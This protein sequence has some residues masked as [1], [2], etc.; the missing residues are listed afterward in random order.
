MLQN[1]IIKS[2][3]V[4]AFLASAL[5][6]SKT[7]SAATIT[8]FTSNNN[9]S[10]Y[11]PV[12]IVEGYDQYNDV[13]IETYTKRVNGENVTVVGYYDRLP[14]SFTNWLRSSGRDLIFITF[15]DTHRDVRDLANEFRTALNTINQMKVGN[16]PNAVIG[17]SAGG[18]IARWGLKEMENSGLN[19][20]TSL[21]ITYDT[22]HRGASVPESIIDGLKDLK[23]KIPFGQLGE[24]EAL[25]NEWRSLTSTAAKQMLLG[26]NLSETFFRELDTLGYPEQLARMAVAN[27]SGSGVTINLPNNAIV[28]DYKAEILQISNEYQTLREEIQKPCTYPCDPLRNS[29]YDRAPGGTLNSFELYWSRLE[30]AARETS[31]ALFD[32]DVYFKN[33][34]LHSHTFVTTLSALD[35]KNYDLNTPIT[36]TME[37]YSPFDDVAYNST[38][39]NHETV[40][41]DFANGNDGDINNWLRNY[42]ISNAQIPS[43]SNKIDPIGDVKNLR[44][45]WVVGGTNLLTWNQVSGATHYEILLRTYSGYV[46][47]KSVS[48][49]NTSII[50]DGTS[51]VAVRACNS[52]QCGYP[53]YSTAIWRNSSFMAF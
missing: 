30:E 49:R 53:D 17:F 41:S 3:F 28:Y 1:H 37:R 39:R 4:F 2:I 25:N 33:E 14:S 36:N 45:E 10:I 8:P 23:D 46:K 22:P 27:G 13:E 18:L 7:S 19:H 15:D 48:S 43:R 26:H 6:A 29:R 50:V 40:D 5:G 20:E 16:H 11:K 12:I 52:S 35:I 44:N 51:R 32:L 24:G 21:F 42:H 38:N 9:G 47:I 34:S 31:G